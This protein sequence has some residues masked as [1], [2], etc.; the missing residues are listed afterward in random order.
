MS[1]VTVSKQSHEHVLYNQL[2]LRPFS[3]RRDQIVQT[4]RQEEV[5]LG[6]LDPTPS[7]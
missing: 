3:G 1:P 4:V 5:S 7:R 2:P 6:M